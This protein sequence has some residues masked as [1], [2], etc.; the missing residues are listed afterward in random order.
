MSFLSLLNTLAS[1]TLWSTNREK[2]WE[3]WEEQNCW[4]CNTY[5]WLVDTDTTNLWL[6]QVPN[7]ENRVVLINQGQNY[8][9]A[10][11]LRS[12]LPGEDYIVTQVN[13]HISN[14][15]STYFY[16]RVRELPRL[17]LIASGSH[18]QH[19]SWL[20]D[21][22]LAGEDSSDCD[23]D[24]DIWLH[25]V[26]TDF[27]LSQCLPPLIGWQNTL[28]ISD[29]SSRVMS[30]HYWPNYGSEDKFGDISVS[31]YEEAKVILSSDWLTQMY[32]NLWLVVSMLTLFGG[33]YVWGKMERS[34]CWLTSSS[35]SGLATAV[36]T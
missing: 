9:N 28:L 31:V 24:Q 14:F 10:S 16:E 23:A 26:N 7:D 36:L 27:W 13:T 33:E 32:A 18:G 21:N 6:V 20:L 30:A 1:G 2:C 35:Q 34:D 11:R 3:H 12:L 25:Q 29:W 15:L 5:L 17:I 8:I 22:D 19:S 4:Y